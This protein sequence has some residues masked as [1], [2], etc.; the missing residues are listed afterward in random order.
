MDIQD[1]ISSGKLELFVLGDLNETEQQEVLAMAKKYPEI[2]QEITAIEEAMLA[3]DEVSGISPSSGIKNK[4]FET[5]EAENKKHSATDIPDKPLQKEVR[6][7]K[8]V[9]L[10]NPWKTFA[11]AASVV[12]LV[13]VF[14]AIYY[15]NQYSDAEERL[16]ISLQQ[17][18]VLAEE[19]QANQ[20][21]LKSLDTGMEKFI[22]GNFDKI[23]MKGEGFPMQE[24]ALVD[25]FWDKE[26]KE[27]LISVNQLAALDEEN[28]YQLWAIGEDG[29]I[30]IGLVNPGKRIDLQTM[31][32]AS[33]AQAFAITIEPKGGSESPTLEKLVVLGE[34]S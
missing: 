29:P 34:V 7:G 28:D 25:V 18:G 8:E 12:A 32:I 33:G 15:A 17:N 30:G 24:D 11:V 26:S 13:S 16:A 19:I 1:Y 6:L 22:T 4:I 21:K 27:V 31:N 10:A 5:L 14:V 20:V 2:E 9:P 23:P 3:I